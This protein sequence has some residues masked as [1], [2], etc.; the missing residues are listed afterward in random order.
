M[1]DSKRD[2]GRKDLLQLVGEYL[3]DNSFVQLGKIS[4][5]YGD[6][7]QSTVEITIGEKTSTSSAEGNG[8]VDAVIKAIEKVVE[9]KIELDEFL[10]QSMAKGSD[11]VCK[12]HMRLMHNHKPYHGFASHTDIVL[13]SAQAF[14]DAI[15]KLPVKQHAIN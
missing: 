2:I 7:V 13:A 5:Q 4:Y 6:V 14:V 15:N 1:A 9:Q 10:I 3:E 8:P 12:V 11:D